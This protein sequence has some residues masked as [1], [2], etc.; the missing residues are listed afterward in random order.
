MQN[1]HTTEKKLSLKY[2]SEENQPREKLLKLG[3]AHLS[4]AELLAILIGS[5]NNEDNAVQL[6]EKIL[7][8]VAG[9]L[10]E[11][12]KKSVEYLK[13]FKGIGDA[14]ALTFVAALELGRRRQKND[15]IEHEQICN[16]RDIYEYIF[17]DLID[18]QHEEFWLILLN[19]ANH[20]IGKKKISSGGT[21]ATVVEPKMIVKFA[22]DAMATSIILIH[23]H[24]SGNLKPSEVDI[25][26]TQ[27]IKS[28][29]SYFDIQVYDHIIFSHTGYY[30]FADA[31]IL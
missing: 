14:K 22:L 19:R 20:I 27:K 31:N 8:S 16:S 5:G 30:S 24:P 18:L 11:L 23:N 29:C 13:E 12:G 15:L 3:K 2:Q 25:K 7:S 17:K 10:T 28:A 1:Q 21:T 4:N 26:L 9:N 6:C